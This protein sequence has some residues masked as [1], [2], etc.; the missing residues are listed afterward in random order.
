M[1]LVEYDDGTPDWHPRK[2]KKQM[3]DLWEEIRPMYETFHAYVRMKLRK[4]DEFKDSVGKCSY[5]PIHFTGG[6]LG[7]VT[8]RKN[9]A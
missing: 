3:E 7:Q 5:I 1:W 9:F 6:F 2:F 4:I 8:F